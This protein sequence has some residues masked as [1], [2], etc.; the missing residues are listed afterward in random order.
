MGDVHRTLFYWDKD[1]EAQVTTSH[2]CSSTGLEIAI[3]TRVTYTIRID[4]SLSLYR[5][6]IRR[7]SSGAVRVSCGLVGRGRGGQERWEVGGAAA[8]EVLGGGGGGGRRRP[9]GFEL[10]GW[11][12]ASWPP[13][14]NTTT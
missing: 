12:A 10:P 1:A 7:G 3:R 2:N 8:S 4:R 5:F 6:L 9:L 13:A 14:I 11:W